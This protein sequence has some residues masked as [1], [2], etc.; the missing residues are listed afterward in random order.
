MRAWA[1]A[2]LVMFTVSVSFAQTKAELGDAR[3]AFK[4]GQKMYGEGNYAEAVVAFKKAYAITG[5][6]LVMGQVALAYEKGG[7]YQA[8]LQA[9]RIY[10]ASLPKSDRGPV[11]QL[12]VRYQ[13]E[14]DA[15]NSRPLVLPSTAAETPA[16]MTKAPPAAGAAAAT[17][18]TQQPEKAP[19]PVTQPRA[20]AEARDNSDDADEGAD[21][22][23]G[24]QSSAGPAKKDRLWTWVAAGSAGA[25]AV[26][27]LVVGL[28]AQ[29]KFDELDQTCRGSCPPSDI[30]AV[31]NRALA[32]DILWGVAGAAA[33]TAVILYFV[34]GKSD[35]AESRTGWIFTPVGAAGT[36]GLGA[37][38]RY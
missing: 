30:S 18:A 11:D 28:S 31:E 26:G 4:R 35:P 38:L 5:D 8:A 32:A 6:G 33:L 25:L 16:A 10:R 34:E 7:D 22:E 37:Q 29:S 24:D 20:D 19:T 36:V 15:G 12:A 9:L 3:T 13:R 1:A 14:I 23:K 27:A 21:G 17:S 2:L